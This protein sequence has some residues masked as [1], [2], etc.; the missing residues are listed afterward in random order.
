MKNINLIVANN[1]NAQVRD[2]VFIDLMEHISNRIQFQVFFQTLDQIFDHIVD[3]TFDH[4]RS[5]NHE[6]N[7]NK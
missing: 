5:N 6:S 1:I 3:Q 2:L 7:Y 4:I